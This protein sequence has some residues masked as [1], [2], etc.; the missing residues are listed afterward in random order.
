MASF[1]PIQFLSLLN[2]G[3]TCDL[4]ETHYES[5]QTTGVSLAWRR[6]DCPPVGSGDAFFACT[7]DFADI[8]YEEASFFAP[9]EVGVV[10]S[11]CGEEVL[12][13]F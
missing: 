10:F 3:E 6:L 1:Q 12:L 7:Y 4:T 13:G 9:S 5:S 2:V 8:F 11:S